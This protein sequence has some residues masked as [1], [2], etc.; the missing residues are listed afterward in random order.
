MT[1]KRFVRARASIALV[2]L[3]LIATACGTSEEVAQ[4]NGTV[5]V[6]LT[7]FKITVSGTAPAGKPFT[8]KVRNDGKAPHSL[9]LDGAGMTMQTAILAA[10]AAADLP[11]AH[12]LSAGAYKLWCTVGGHKE[13]GMT[14]TLVVAGAGATSSPTTGAMSS[15]Q[16]DRDTEA[17]IKAFPAKTSAVGGTVLR[18]IVRNGVKEF[19]LAAKVVRWEISPGQFVDA[20]GYNGIVPGPEI[21]VRKGDRVRVVVHNELPESTT[22]HFHGLTVPNAM[23]GVPFITQ[24][25]IKTGQTYRYEFTI[26]DDPGTFIYHSHHNAAVQVGRGLYG[27]FI[28]EPRSRSWNVEQ[29][30]FLGD[31]HLG[32]NLNGKSFPATAPIVA[33]RGQKLLVRFLNGGELL[34]PMHMHGFHFTVVSRDG[35]PIQPYTVDTLVIAPGERYDALVTL[36]LKGTWAF[37]CH[38]LTHAEGEHGMFGMVTAVVVA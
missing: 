31:G 11:V 12:A 27:A 19:D 15:E 38:I 33:A 23:D 9:A 3:A 25:L 17:G 21:R 32:Y 18:P 22:M 24:P 35:R 14:G 1:T 29:T 4:T 20:Y 28:V 34:H 2:L 16:M 7:D 8:I 10:G 5:T 36:N 6:S 26:V 37:H 30:L 13:A